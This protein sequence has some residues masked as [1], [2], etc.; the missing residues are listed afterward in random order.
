MKTFLLF[1]E[2]SNRSKKSLE[3]LKSKRESAAEK[4]QKTKSSF[5]QRMKKLQA[6][7][8]SSIENQKKDSEENL[9]YHNTLKKKSNKIQ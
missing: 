3:K 5:Y 8:E 7:R 4:T 1:L 6:K 2:D 9:K